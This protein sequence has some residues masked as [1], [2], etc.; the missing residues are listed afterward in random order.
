MLNLFVLFV[1]QDLSVGPLELILC[2]SERFWHIFHLFYFPLRS[3]VS[4]MASSVLSFPHKSVHMSKACRLTA[5]LGGKQKRNGLEFL[6]ANT[7][8]F[9]L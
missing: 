5:S 4:I 6:N 3:F 8:G 7:W 9:V 1:T 2:V